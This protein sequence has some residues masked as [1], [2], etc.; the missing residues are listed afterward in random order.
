MLAVLGVELLPFISRW[1]QF[2]HF[3]N[4]PLQA[5]AFS[6]QFIL[7]LLCSLQGFDALPPNGPRNTQCGCITTGI[8]IQQI[9][10]GIW[11]AQGGPSVLTVDVHQSLTQLFELRGGGGAAVDPRAAFALQVHRA[12]QQQCV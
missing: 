8:C 10:H 5:F 6:E 7:R 3:A 11:T 2:G 4:L 9:A 1:C 12:A